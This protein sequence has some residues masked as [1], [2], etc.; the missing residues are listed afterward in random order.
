[1]AKKRRQKHK[2][3]GRNSREEIQGQ[4]SGVRSITS[5]KKK[6]QEHEGGGRNCIEEKQG[7]KRETGI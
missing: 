5:S 7:Q 3:G 2:E 6:S 4:S 1:M